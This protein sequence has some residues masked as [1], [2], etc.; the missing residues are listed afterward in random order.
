MKKN[1]DYVQW[2]SA[3]SPVSQKRVLGVIESI[4]ELE[5]TNPKDAYIWYTSGSYTDALGDYD[6]GSI[7]E[8]LSQEGLLHSEGSNNYGGILIGPYVE[9]LQKAK[10]FL[11]KEK[12]PDQPN[13]QDNPKETIRERLIIDSKNMTATYISQAGIS[14]NAPFKKGTSEYA[15]LLHLAQNKNIPYDTVQLVDKLKDARQSAG[16]TAPGK[17]VIDKISA[18]RKKLGKEVIKSTPNGYVIECEIVMI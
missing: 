3:L 2:L 9:K 13:K 7:I 10:V 14:K 1:E 17:R 6:D 15:I 12:V 16:Y 18:I 11:K 8:R 4:L 5:K